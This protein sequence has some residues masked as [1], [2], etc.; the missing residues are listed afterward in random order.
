MTIALQPKDVAFMSPALARAFHVAQMSV[1]GATF[2]VYILL[3]YLLLKHST[4]ELASYRFYIL[5]S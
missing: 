1:Y 4:R 2:V 3:F 5:G